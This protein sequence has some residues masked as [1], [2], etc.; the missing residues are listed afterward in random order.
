M[1]K[2]IICIDIYIYTFW[3]KAI[4]ACGP[5]TCIFWTMFSLRSWAMQK[6]ERQ[7]ESRT[8]WMLGICNSPHAAAW[9]KVYRLAL[10]SLSST[11]CA[12]R[13][14]G[15]LVSLLAFWHS[16]RFSKT[17]FSCID[18]ATE[19]QMEVLA[20][21]QTVTVNWTSEPWMPLRLSEMIR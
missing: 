20:H 7:E 12:P 9:L 13:I 11:R 16:A 5:I 4:L 17:F 21:W 14:Q 1:N 2:R 3:V 18:G 6:K 19:R 10:A 8:R 15:L